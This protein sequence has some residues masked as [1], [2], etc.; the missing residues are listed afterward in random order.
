MNSSKN[1]AKKNAAIFS[2]MAS[3]GMTL[4][5][6]LVGFLTGS[7][8]II[9][10]AIHSL[11]D[12]MATIV[13][14]FAVKISAEPADHNHH[15]GHDKIESLAALVET[16]LLFGTSL[17]I[18]YEAGLRVFGKGGELVEVTWYAIAVIAVSIV[19]DF[20][21]S[22]S[23]LKVAKATGSQA[24]EADALHFASDMYSSLA[25]LVGLVFTYFG[26]TFADSL[27]AL[28]VS[29]MIFSAG[30]E[31]GKKSFAVLMDEAPEGVSAHICSLAKKVAG[32]GGVCDVN[33]RSLDGTKIFTDLSIL[34]DGSLTMEAAS[35]IKKEV[36]K[37]IESS[38]EGSHVVVH[39]DT[40][41]QA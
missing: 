12:F 25:V 6:F 24:L 5:K 22:R 38:Y 29:L 28:I 33:V 31:L 27:S 26:V 2:M 34:V 39:I 18:M 41:C 21:R 36:K 20:N 17:W 13:T 16:G 3:L 23:L 32:V 1:Q 9:S 15:Y 10:E 19:V 40:M 8:G 14:Y 35:S 37:S 7:L 30:I 11:V 4:S